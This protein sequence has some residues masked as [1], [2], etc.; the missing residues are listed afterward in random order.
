MKS[1]YA[2]DDKTVKIKKKEK[3]LIVIERCLV[4]QDDMRLERVD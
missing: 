1:I 4:L 2:V 3:N